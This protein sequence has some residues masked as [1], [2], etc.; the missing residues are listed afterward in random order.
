MEW[1]EARLQ[2]AQSRQVPL[3]HIYLQKNAGPRFDSVRRWVRWP[4]LQL[5]N[6]SLLRKTSNRPQ[7][8]VQWRQRNN[9][10]WTASPL[11]LTFSPPAMMTLGW[12][13]RGL[14]FLDGVPD[15]GV[16]WLKFA[17]PPVAEELLASVCIWCREEV[18]LCFLSFLCLIFC[19]SMAFLLLKSSDWAGRGGI[20][21]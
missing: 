8:A 5:N 7:R 2:Y 16:M 9:K 6:S 18:V 13:V 14:W 12:W 15:A 10:H 4:R 17:S 11:I 19:F 3:S 20:F 1:N 21:S